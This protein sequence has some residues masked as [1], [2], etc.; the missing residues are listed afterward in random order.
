MRSRGDPSR[1]P[2]VSTR[3][4]VIGTDERRGAVGDVQSGYYPADGRKYLKPS[5]TADL[6]ELN[7]RIAKMLRRWQ[8]TL[9]PGRPRKRAKITTGAGTKDGPRTR[10]RG[11]T[12]NQ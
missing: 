9:E 6:I 4:E 8:A 12:K 10:D 2:G 5:E 3:S 7:E 11:R 1:T